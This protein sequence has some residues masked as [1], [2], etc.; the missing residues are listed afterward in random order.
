MNKNEKIIKKLRDIQVELMSVKNIGSL[1]HHNIFM[2]FHNMGLAITDLD[3]SIQT[4]EKEL[5]ELKRDVQNVLFRKYADGYEQ[6]EYWTSFDRLKVL[7]GLKPIY[8]DEIK[9][10]SNEKLSKSGVSND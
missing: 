3:N 8:E 9:T 5:E 1:Q 2:L 7:N 10:W 4:T 6:V